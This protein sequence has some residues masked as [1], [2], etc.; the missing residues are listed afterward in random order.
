MKLA[1]TSEEIQ[2]LH[3]M[4]VLRSLVL[5]SDGTYAPNVH[6]EL[7][8]EY[9]SLGYDLTKSFAPFV[10]SLLNAGL[11]SIVDKWDEG[12]HEVVD[13]HEENNIWIE[14]RRKKA[15]STSRGAD[16]LGPNRVPVSKIMGQER[17]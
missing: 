6:D 7:I 1:I 12:F 16:S 13:L 14:V 9:G 8:D 10:L 11:I 5:T 15:E 4:T 2:K 17:K 3:R